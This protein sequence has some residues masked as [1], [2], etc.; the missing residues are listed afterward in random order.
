MTF[1]WPLALLGLALVPL[2][3]AGYVLLQRRRMRYAARFTNLDLLAN[4]VEGSPGWRRHLPAAL[5]LVALAALIVGVARP[6]AEISVPREQATV[7]LAVDVSASM[8]A[9]DVA[10]SR[11]EAAR[12]AAKEFVANLPDGFRVGVVG[13]SRGAYVLAPPTEGGEDAARAL[14]ELETESGTAIGEGIAAS[15]TS[16]RLAQSAA[17]DA[18]ADEAPLVVL[19]LSDGANTIG[20]DPMVAAEEAREEGVPVFT[21]AL[22]TEDGTATV[23]DENGFE[24][25]MNV[26][27]DPETLQEIA[28]RTGGRFYDAPT[29]DEL[30][31]VY[32]DIG[33]QVGTETE[34]RQV[35]V[36][37]PVL[38]TVLLAAGAD[39]SALLFNRIP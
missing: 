38:G 31:S 8:E 30:R 34:E 7:V 33:S 37:L 19:L 26:P 21:V 3:L 23:P 27:P 18:P 4:V 39:L 35:T 25:T 28:E 12:A 5:A 14:D 24:R 20:R 2:A 15:V 16:G 29:A 10:P 22:G 13:F 6:H 32:D 36:H 9:T 17:R 11:L 1:A